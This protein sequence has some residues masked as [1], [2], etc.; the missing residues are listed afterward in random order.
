MNRIKV[1]Y[2]DKPIISE[3]ELKKK[4]SFFVQKKSLLKGGLR[5]IS[6]DDPLELSKQ[7]WFSKFYENF[8]NRKFKS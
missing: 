3:N 5:A 4:T 2:F 8:N 6:I 1:Y 7:N